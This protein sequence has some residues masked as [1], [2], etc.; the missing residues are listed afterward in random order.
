MAPKF[1]KRSW[2]IDLGQ[3]MELWVGLTDTR[4]VMTFASLD[5]NLGRFKLDWS[6]PAHDHDMCHKLGTHAEGGTET[7]MRFRLFALVSIESFETNR[8]MKQR[9]WRR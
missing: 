4:P 7:L 9:W 8:W 3:L 2:A 1:E 6:R 5:L